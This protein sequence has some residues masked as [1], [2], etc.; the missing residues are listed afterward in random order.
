MANPVIAYAEAHP[1]PV[2]IGAVAIGLVLLW[3]MGSGSSAQASDASGG[4]GDPAAAYFAAASA[5]AQAGDAV[6]IAQINAQ[7]E[8]AQT[9]IGANAA[10]ANA[11]TWATAQT[12]QTLNTNATQVSLA[13][14]AVQAGAVQGLSQAALTA[15]ISNTTPGNSGF[16]GLFSSGPTTTTTPSPVATSAVNQLDNYLNG[17]A[18]GH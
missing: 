16:F 4:G 18:P 8:T 13:P 6:Q 5:Q 12:S 1:V 14:F 15:P 3:L 9:L 7:A 2:A 11:T 17:Y 10:T